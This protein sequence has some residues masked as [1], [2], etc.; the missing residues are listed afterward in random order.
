MCLRNKQLIILN[1]I[2]FAWF[3]TDDNNFKLDLSIN[4]EITPSKC[5]KLEYFNSSQLFIENSVDYNHFNALHDLKQRIWINKILIYYHLPPLVNIIF[6]K[7]KNIIVNTHSVL[8]HYDISLYILNRHIVTNELILKSIGSSIVYS[9]IYDKCKNILFNSIVT[10]LPIE[11]N[12]TVVKTYYFFKQCN[13]STF[14]INI[15]MKYLYDFHCKA[16]EDDIT[17]FNNL[18]IIPKPFYTKEDNDIKKIRKYLTK[19]VSIDN[20]TIDW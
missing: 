5:V 7:K 16:L 4:P 9:T 11:K 17:I 20:N 14:C 12:H 18:N 19:Y 15:F 2:I 13:I 1:D 10:S 6:K 3:G 8:C